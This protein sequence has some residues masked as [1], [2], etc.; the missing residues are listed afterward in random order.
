M[1]E[2][3]RILLKP[4][5]ETSSNKVR[6]HTATALYLRGV[7]SDT[8]QLARPKRLRRGF[9]EVEPTPGRL[10]S[11]SQT[12]ASSYSRFAAKAVKKKTMIKLA[13]EGG[14]PART[15]TENLAIMSRML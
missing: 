15:R 2:N 11:S 9:R 8:H 10:R 14:G 3:C 6:K 12:T 4:Q 7:R 5:R 1:T 13:T